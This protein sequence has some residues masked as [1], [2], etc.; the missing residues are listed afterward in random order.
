[1]SANTFDVAIAGEHIAKKFGHVQA[2]SDANVK[3]RRGEVVALFGDNGAGK[4]TFL[5]TLLGMITP[6]EGRVV[7]AD[8]PARLRSIRDAHHLGVQAVHQDLALAP[9]LS[10]IDNMFIGNEILRP[11]VASRFGILNRRDMAE[12]VDAAL[13]ELSIKLP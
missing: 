9:E 13:R 8:E 6:D 5:K 4:S 11:G 2:L 12:K 1:M 10:V 3:V 7:V